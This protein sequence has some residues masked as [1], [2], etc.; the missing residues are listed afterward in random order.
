MAPRVSVIVPCF[1]DGVLAI[2]AVDSVDEAEPV[3]VAVVD[4]GSTEAE[5]RD[6]LAQLEDRGI[7]VIHRQNGGLSAARM[8]GLDGTTAPYVYPLDSDDQ[9]VP[10]ALC[11]MADALERRPDAAFAFGDLEIFGDF[12]GLYPSPPEFSRWAQTWA[13]FIPVGS[14]IRRSALEGVGAWE[15]LGPDVPSGYEDWDLWLKLGEAGWTGVRVPGIVYRRR[16]VKGTRML[17]RARPRHRDLLRRLR[18]RHPAT[19]ER[20][21]TLARAERVPLRR[22][23]AYPVIFGIRNTNLLPYALEDRLILRYMAWRLR[24]AETRSAVTAR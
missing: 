1:N 3:E 9:L 20:R 13:N 18:E 2:E 7:R 21:R 24:R 19:F 15:S 12:R 22:R 4:D 6:A 10:G 17:G 8:T 14:L 5:T 11:A 16:R 23:L